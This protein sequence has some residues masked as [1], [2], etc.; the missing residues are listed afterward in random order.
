MTMTVTT[1]AKLQ[2]D[3]MTYIVELFMT[4]FSQTDSDKGDDDQI[5]FYLAESAATQRQQQ[6]Y[7]QSTFT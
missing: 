7:N 2:S 1:F 6:P 3:H 5:D 4:W